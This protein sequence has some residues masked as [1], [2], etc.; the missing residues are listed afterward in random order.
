MTHRSAAIPIVS[1]ALPILFIQGSVLVENEGSHPPPERCIAS[2][3]I[4]TEFGSTFDFPVH[5]R[6]SLK[7]KW[8][9]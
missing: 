9:L 3:A 4:T 5:Q 7:A 8:Y 2:P 1:T 6:C